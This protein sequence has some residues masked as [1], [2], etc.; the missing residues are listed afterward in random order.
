M[1]WKTSNHKIILYNNNNYNN[2]LNNSLT[3]KIIQNQ[4]NKSCS[5]KT[6]QLIKENNQTLLKKNKIVNM[7]HTFSNLKNKNQLQSN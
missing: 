4:N 1:N 2:K 3:L 5:F 7:N 6:C